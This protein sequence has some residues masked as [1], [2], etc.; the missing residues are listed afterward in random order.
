M[1]AENIGVPYPS[2]KLYLIRW[3]FDAV[4]LRVAAFPLLEGPLRVADWGLG[5]LTSTTKSNIV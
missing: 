2:V 1:A 4:N 3:L 5:R